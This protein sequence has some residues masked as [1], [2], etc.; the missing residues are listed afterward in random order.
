MTEQDYRDYFKHKY[1]KTSSFT[2]G[3]ALMVSDAFFV[4]LSIG[5]SFFIINFINHSWINFRSF[6]E[7]A[8]YL[9]PMLA[10][11]YAAGLYPGISLPPAEE[12]K[13]FAVCCFFV[14][15]GI[16]LSITVEEAEDKIPLVVAFILASP[17]A[18]I[19]L[20]VGRELARHVLAKRRWFGVPAVIYVNGDSGNFVISRLLKRQ[21]FGYK[22]ALIIDST[23]TG[24]SDYLGIPVFPASKEI[25]SIIKETGIKV[26]ILCGYNLDTTDINMYYRYTINIPHIHDTN[27]MSSY[28][29]DFGGILG[30]SSTHNLTKKVSLALKRLL[31]FFLLLISAPVTIPLTIVVAI[32]VKL[33]SEGPIFY[34]HTRIGQNGREF[35]CW[36]FRS[37]VIDAD[38]QL[39]KILAENPE[40][41]AEWERDRKFTNDPRITKIG[42]ILRKTS[43][44]EIP[45]FFNILTGEMSFIG[46]RP[47]TRPELTR[48]GNKSDF[49]LSVKPGL[50]GMWQISGRSDTG[51]EERIILDSYYIQNW[52]IWLDLWII[53]KTIY[54]VLKGKGAY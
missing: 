30:F 36:K 41:R 49:I 31:D 47:V 50:S 29:R 54:V 18:A 26:A 34:G 28:V 20:P 46:P 8:I 4:M 25:V 5:I 21:D 40:M 2:S 9:P 3:A 38:K 33:T 32:A 22:P 16:A 19:T 15:V 1:Y 52:S 51:Y 10:V 27:T 53:I 45:Q 11:F 17:I 24:S 12:V 13:K 7:Y 44:D 14:F 42:K 43:I 39:E 6:V 37:M 23:A 48:Y 35:K